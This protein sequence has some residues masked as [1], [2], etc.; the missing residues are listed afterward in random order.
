MVHERDALTAHGS[1]ALAADS[2]ATAAAAAP[3]SD[4]DPTPLIGQHATYVREKAELVRAHGAAVAKLEK[5]LQSEKEDKASLLAKLHVL[6]HSSPARHVET[7]TTGT[8]DRE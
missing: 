7:D 1:S 3:P 8:S 5:D 6:E 2:A 4:D